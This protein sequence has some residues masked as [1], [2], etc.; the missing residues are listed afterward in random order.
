M[1]STPTAACARTCRLVHVCTPSHMQV[2]AR[3]AVLLIIYFKGLKNL[4]KMS[5]LGCH[6]FDETSV[7]I[8]KEI[9]MLGKWTNRAFYVQVLSF[10]ERRVRTDFARREVEGAYQEVSRGQFS[11]YVSL[12]PSQPEL[13]ATWATLLRSVCYFSEHWHA[14]KRFKTT[15]LKGWFGVP[16]PQGEWQHS[17]K[18]HFH[19]N[20]GCN[21][22]SSYM[23]ISGY[24]P[25]S[26]SSAV[27]SS[28]VV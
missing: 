1:I 12:Y 4:I 28:L 20:L 23:L 10:E 5:L 27:G 18:N 22:S 21:W 14:K 3:E 16:L 2:R 9:A 19:S 6:C 15:G 25:S 8:E 13:L 24:I 26:N 17:R 11:T 7:W